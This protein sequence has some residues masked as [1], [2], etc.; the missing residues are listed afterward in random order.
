MGKKNGKG[1]EYHFDNGNLEFEG[2]Y[3]NG[4]KNWK[5][6]K[7]NEEGKLEFEGEFLYDYK[8]KGKEYLNEKLEYEGEYFFIIQNIME[9]DMIKMVILYMK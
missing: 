2:E 4:K 5:G 8:L 9:K 1:K 3:L 7:Y 6:K